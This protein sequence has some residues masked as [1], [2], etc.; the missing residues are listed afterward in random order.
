VFIGRP[1]IKRFAL[2]YR[3]VVLSVWP[4]CP[5]LSVCNVGVLWA[6]VW[7]DQHETWR[8]GRP[9]SWSHCVGWR[10][11]GLLI[12]VAQKRR[13]TQVHQHSNGCA[14][15]KAAERQKVTYG[16]DVFVQGFFRRTV[17]NEQRL[18]RSPYAC[19]NAGNCDIGRDSRNGCQACRFKK[20]LDTGMSTDC[21]LIPM[22]CD[23]VSSNG[24]YRATQCT[25]AKHFA[26]FVCRPT[27]EF[28]GNLL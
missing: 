15:G 18:G 4:A 10:P 21:E 13:L 5:D 19:Q 20:C 26:V 6:N 24:F 14:D 28:L 8:G 7:T 25:Q 27:S 16:V 12:T 11:L 2:R 3:T 9:R 23:T 1:F 22:R 17:Q